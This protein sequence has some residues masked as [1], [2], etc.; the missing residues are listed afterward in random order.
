[1]ATGTN[2][3]FQ[4]RV[5]R[6]PAT[7]LCFIVASTLIMCT[8][9]YIDSIS[10]PKFSESISIGPV[11]MIVHTSNIEITNELL[12][13]IQD[14]PY[15]TNVAVLD[16]SFA[17]LRLD[18]TPLWTPEYWYTYGKVRSFN[19]EYSETYP[20][21][22]DIV[23]GRFPTN[24]TEIAISLR[25]AAMT[26]IEVGTTVF[27]SFGLNEPKTPLTV[28]GMF[29]LTI[30][31][32]AFSYFD[33]IAIVNTSLL[34]SRNRVTRI[35]IDVDRT[36]V[37]PF[38]IMT[39]QQ[40][41][42]TIENSVDSLDPGYTAAGNSEFYVANILHDSLSEYSSWKNSM[43]ISQILRIYSSAI[44]AIILGFLG[45]NHNLTRR[46]REASFYLMRGSSKLRVR[47]LFLFELLTISSL[48]FILALVTSFMTSRIAL[49][50]RG[51]LSFEPSLFFSDPVFITFES[52]IF[53]IFSSLLLPTLLFAIIETRKTIS[54]RLVAAEGRL[55]R[56]TKGFNQIRLDVVTLF[57]AF[58]MIGILNVVHSSNPTNSLLDLLSSTTP[59][60]VFLGIAR[61]SIK[62]LQKASFPLSRVFAPIVGGLGKIGIRRIGTNNRLSGLVFLSLLF[63]IAFSI[64]SLS[65]FYVISN[66]QL[67][68]ARFAIGSDL[69]V[70]L[71][72]S[73]PQ[74][75]T[76]FK[77]IVNEYNE[78]D[79]ASIVSTGNLYLSEG[80]SGRFR[81]AA[82]NPDEYASIGFDSSGSRLNES[83]INPSLI[84]LNRSMTSAIIAEDIATRYNLEIGNTLRTFTSLDYENLI[85]FEIIQIVPTLTLPRVIDFAASSTSSISLGLGNIWLNIQYLANIAEL[86]ESTDNFLCIGMKDVQR[87]N[88]LADNLS[89]VNSTLITP[90][91]WSVALTNVDMCVDQEIYRIDRA[92]DT[93]LILTSWMASFLVVVMYEVETAQI[94]KRTCAILKVLGISTRQLYVIHIAEV[95]TLCITCFLVLLMY[96]PVNTLAS[97]DNSMIRYGTSYIQFPSSILLEI[98]INCLLSLFPLFFLIVLL[99]STISI[100]KAIRE[101]NFH[102]LNYQWTSAIMNME[103]D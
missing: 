23:S 26:Y 83:W 94:R 59:I 85:E 75:L 66:T 58:L 38:N 29:N 81:F 2:Q 92:I 12:Q 49:S 15:V 9:I 20:D 102:S 48:S 21:V 43:R 3:D 24:D 101:K 39:S 70:S 64:S 32:I 52:L 86:N 16:W 72:S 77:S 14:I 5:R 97:L 50:S 47:S 42:V 51:L 96:G 4:S 62:F 6:L 7:L 65:N 28:V 35:D 69:T 60:L 13:D 71:S 103:V 99:L 22:F 93:M 79:A 100:T 98:S 67:T 89:N 74:E 88:A 18:N 57:G 46:E 53:G 45:V 34:D 82:I 55:A 8:P 44:L 78:V 31:D 87:S 56:T 63:T 95:C 41:L 73:D 19:H 91:D 61:L 76:D 54:K 90:G 11:G 40:Y 1:M 30:S 37:Q 17:Y 68:N 27:Y 36:P 10:L 25:A 80:S 84:E 33:S